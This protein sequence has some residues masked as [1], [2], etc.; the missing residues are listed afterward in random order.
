ML[1]SH[2]KMHS[3]F[4]V[5]MVVTFGKPCMGNPKGAKGVVYEVY[6]LGSHHGVSIVFE[7]GLHDGFSEACIEMLDVV[8]CHIA[9]H[10]QNYQFRSVEKL[11]YD[12][13][14]GLF[15]AALAA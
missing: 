5:G 8:P 11:H 3:A 15:N 12:F 1:R 14:N 2:N 4:P 13:N 9:R 7:N 10:L 6:T